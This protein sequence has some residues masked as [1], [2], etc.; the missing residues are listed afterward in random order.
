MDVLCSPY[1]VAEISFKYKGTS[2]ASHK[3]RNE[4]IS[5]GTAALEHDRSTL[6]ASL[7]KEINELKGIIGELTIANKTLKNSTYNKR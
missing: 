2:L 7:T 3:C 6:E 4:F 5:A 1:T